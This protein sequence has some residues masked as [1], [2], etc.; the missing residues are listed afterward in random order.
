MIKRLE[1][2]I[3]KLNNAIKK[4]PIRIEIPKVIKIPKQNDIPKKDEIAGDNIKKNDHFK[5][6][7]LR[8]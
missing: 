3:A 8:T 6:T 2:K 1:V 5:W 4:R 7:E